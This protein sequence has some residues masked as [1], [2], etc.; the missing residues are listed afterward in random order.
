MLGGELNQEVAVV[1]AGALGGGEVGD[2]SE[3]ERAL[4]G[5]HRIRQETV[6][7]CQPLA[8]EDHVV[9]SRTEV[10]P[11]KWHLAH[12]SW[13]FETFILQP[14]HPGYRPL[15][16]SYG[17]LFNS[18]YDSVGPQFPRAQRGLLSRPTVDEVHHYRAH[19]DAA[20]VALLER[21]GEAHRAEVHARL[22]LGLQ[23]EQQHQE[24]LLTDIKHNFAVNPLQPA[25]RPAAPQGGGEA[26]TLGWSEFP[27]GNAAVGHSGEGFGFD[28]EG[29]RHRVLLEPYRLASRCVTNGEFLTFMEEGGYGCPTLWLSDGWAAVKR[30]GWAAPGYWQ[31]RD[32]QWWQM[33]LGGL[34]PVDPAA[35]VCHV[36]WFEADAYARWAGKR[37]PREEEWEVAAAGHPPVGNLLES[38]ALH[39][40]RA[41]AGRLT[42]LFGDV[43]EWT[44]SPYV[45]YPGYQRTAD[46]FGEYNGKFMIGQM[47]L[48]G[49]SCVTPPG[50]IRP[51]YRNFFYPVDRW[52]FSGFR[53]AE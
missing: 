25:Y 45:A 1:G 39:P 42:Q 22:E 19:V 51:S 43:W 53:L 32:G 8:V 17:F 49:G 35:P 18:Y 15:H 20:M 41:P 5:Y 2:S 28:N 11:P 24:L 14:F 38:G 29:P 46:A 26:P 34:C 30:G 33:T 3:R 10:S 44:Q 50:H 31:R 47:V 13:F 4:V 7:I 52:Q 6:A 12:T 40:R 23:H 36:S 16:P 37:L 27:G 21:V 9:Q 48:R